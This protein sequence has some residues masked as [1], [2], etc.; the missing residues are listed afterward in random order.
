MSMNGSTLKKE[1]DA[2]MLNSLCIKNQKTMF[3]IEDSKKD[4]NMVLQ[5]VNQ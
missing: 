3:L 1:D 5:K 2:S 4:F